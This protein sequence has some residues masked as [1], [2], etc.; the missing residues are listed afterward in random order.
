MYVNPG[1]KVAFCKFKFSLCDEQ[2]GREFCLH[3]KHCFID[4][5]GLDWS[6]LDQ[7]GLGHQMK[8]GVERVRS[9][10]GGGT[11]WGSVGS[12]WDAAIIKATQTACRYSHRKHRHHHI[13]FQSLA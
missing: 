1:L 9:E 11:G 7:V 6:G 3:R 10:L 5:T 8:V 2:R 12:K 13:A 4:C